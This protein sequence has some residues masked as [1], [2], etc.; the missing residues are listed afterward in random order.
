MIELLAADP[1]AWHIIWVTMV[2]VAVAAF[3][4]WAMKLLERPRSD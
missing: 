1:G 3:V 4:F 2:I